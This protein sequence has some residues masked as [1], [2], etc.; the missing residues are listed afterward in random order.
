MVS[1]REPGMT[2]LMLR[3]LRLILDNG[4]FAKF[5]VGSGT[6]LAALKRRRM[7]A[8]PPSRL[9]GGYRITNKGRAVLDR[10]V[11]TQPRTG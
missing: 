2:H 1:D 7:I 4:S 3:V 5:P 8:Q 6:A 9:V 11:P 10:A